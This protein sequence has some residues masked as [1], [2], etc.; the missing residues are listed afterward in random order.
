MTKNTVFWCDY[1]TKEKIKNKE[2]GR[3]LV[4]GATYG[5]LSPRFWFTLKVCFL[6]T[7]RCR[8]VV[9]EYWS[10]QMAFGLRPLL[11]ESLEDSLQK[12]AVKKV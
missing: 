12:K 3:L 10:T 7:I 8:S 6:R 9:T 1:R 5:N 4:K 2:M 11:I